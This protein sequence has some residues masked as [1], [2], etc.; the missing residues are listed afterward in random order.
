VIVERSLRMAAVGLVLPVLAAC[1]GSFIPATTQP[2]TAT[3]ARLRMDVTENGPESISAHPTA[4]APEAPASPSPSPSPS[5][6][7]SPASS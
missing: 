1:G 2:A 6:V 7:P 3:S 5:P 4:F